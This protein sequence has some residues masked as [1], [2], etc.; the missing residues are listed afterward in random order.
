MRNTEKILPQ[1]YVAVGGLHSFVHLRAQWGSQQM[2]YFQLL[3][4]S[5]LGKTPFAMTIHAN[6]RLARVTMWYSGVCLCFEPLLIQ[7]SA[8]RR[9]YVTQWDYRSTQNIFVVVDRSSPAFAGQVFWRHFWQCPAL[10]SAA[11]C[12]QKEQCCMPLRFSLSTLVIV[13]PFLV[14]TSSGWTRLSLSHS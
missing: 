9:M 3:R 2:T 6:G 12:A 1:Y 8:G 13:L 5:L 10:L 7:R 11:Y 14:C 4:T